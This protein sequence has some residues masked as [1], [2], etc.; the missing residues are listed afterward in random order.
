MKPDL[1][2]AKPKPIEP[3]ASQADASI[4]KAR[5]ETSTYFVRRQKQ[6]VPMDQAK[7]ELAALYRMLHVE[8]L[9]DGISGHISFRDQEEPHHFWVNPFGLLFEEVTPDNLIK[10]DYDGNVLQGDYPVNVA[11]FCI[12]SAIHRARADAN[13]VVHVHSPLGT[14]FSALGRHIE[15][16]DQNCCMYFDDHELY[17]DFHG[18]VNQDEEAQ[19]IC[20]ALGDKSMVILQNHGAITVGEDMAT[21]AHLMLAAERAYSANLN[22]FLYGTPKL[23]DP[24]TAALTREWIAN[25]IGHR[26]E[27]D[28]YLRKV[29][30]RYPEL[31]SLKPRPQ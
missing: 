3:H 29:E 13:C 2:A 18:P 6:A 11:G 25:P 14:V 20:K 16:V 9:D 19:E 31:L 7:Y 24:E 12:H 30:R 23:I 26:I 21:A 10:V 8:G 1:F 5:Q 4:S 17:S 28:A 27:F 22:A 15:P